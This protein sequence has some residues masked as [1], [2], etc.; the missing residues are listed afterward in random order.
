MQK[1]YKYAYPGSNKVIHIWALKA[2]IQRKKK[3]IFYFQYAKLDYLKKKLLM[4]KE[5]K[6]IIV[7]LWGTLILN[8]AA[9]LVSSSFSSWIPGHL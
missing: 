4:Q 8:L 5:I 3:S 1:K 9:W 2:R 7:Y 6:L